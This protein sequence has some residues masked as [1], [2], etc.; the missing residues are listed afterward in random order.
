M[1]KIKIKIS[2]NQ[3]YKK[4]VPYLGK[5][6]YVWNESQK[7]PT[8]YDPFETS[9]IPPK[10]LCIYPEE[11]VI[12]YSRYITGDVS[13]SDF[14]KSNPLQK[15]QKK[16]N[17][18]LIVIYRNGDKVV[19]RNKIAGKIGEAKCHPNDK[20]DFSIGAR[21]AFDRLMSDEEDEKIEDREQYYNGKVVC[22]SRVP[23]FTIGKIYEFVN[24]RV[25]DDDQEIRPFK[26]Y[27]GIKD[28]TTAYE[29]GFIELVE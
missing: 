27:D 7:N 2:S 21:L 17:K 29:R 26:W 3:E 10:T 11:K 14:I 4:I 8:E 9:V 1:N 6:G 5:L 22:I 20:F 23:G 13:V 25:A 24:G 18:D 28:I 15:K 16:P 19:A 12:T